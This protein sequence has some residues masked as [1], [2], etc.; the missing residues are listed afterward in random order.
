MRT[1]LPYWQ[2]ASEAPLDATAFVYSPAYKW[3]GLGGRVLAYRHADYNGHK[4]VWTRD[5][6]CGPVLS[7]KDAPVLFHPLPPLPEDAE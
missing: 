5:G 7:G 4:G 3:M 1:S 2:P 6:R